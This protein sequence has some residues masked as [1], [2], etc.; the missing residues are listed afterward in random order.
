ME[1][2][3]DYGYAQ[4]F[5]G[6]SWLVRIAGLL[7]VV[8]TMLLVAGNI[9]YVPLDKHWTTRTQAWNKA[10]IHLNSI[11]CRNETIRAELQGTDDCLKHRETH[12]QSPFKLAI[13]DTFEDYWCSSGSCLVAQFDIFTLLYVIP[14]LALVAAIAGVAL[15]VFLFVRTYW[16]AR[17]VYEI[18]FRNADH[19]PIKTE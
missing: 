1:R 13:R 7:A 17:R 18:P 14:L 12:E 8:A 5:D 16:S 15:C 4:R 6:L 2:E 9:V 3:Y 19:R 11:V 10:A